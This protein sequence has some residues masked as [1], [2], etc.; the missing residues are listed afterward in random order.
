VEFEGEF[1]N[2]NQAFHSVDALIGENAALFTNVA[3]KANVH[4][5][6]HTHPPFTFTHL[7]IYLLQWMG[8]YRLQTRQRSW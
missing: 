2:L 8:Q 5:H 6:I 7:T 3:V 4:T 1:Q